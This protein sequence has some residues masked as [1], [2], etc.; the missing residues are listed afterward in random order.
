MAKA[1]AQKAAVPKTAGNGA[2][3]TR[4]AETRKA[5]SVKVEAAKVESAKPKAAKA[6]SAKPEAAEAETASAGNDRQDAPQAPDLTVVVQSSEAWFKGI[7][8]LGTEM[9]TFTT[10][11]LQE[12]VRISE[13]LTQCRDLSEALEVQRD[14][15]RQA[16]E[17]YL[18]EANRL[19]SMTA[20]MTRAAWTPLQDEAGRLT[21]N[22][23]WPQQSA[24]AHSDPDPLPPRPSP[25][26]GG[27]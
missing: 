1:T 14:Y 26:R 17:E 21:G 8:A 24:S 7:T 13:A 15:V 9:V 6:E 5:E 11:R 20:D 23:R 27:E 12:G 2:N 16:S 3:Q 4:K 10:H 22:G 18:E 25:S 19:V